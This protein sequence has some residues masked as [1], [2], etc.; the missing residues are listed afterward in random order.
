MDRGFRFG[1]WF[2]EE[3]DGLFFCKGKYE[4]ECLR[5]IADFDPP[6]LHWLLENE[7]LTKDAR[8]KIEEALWL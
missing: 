1:G 5:S 8:S 3:E 4:N 7:D 6:Y 2:E